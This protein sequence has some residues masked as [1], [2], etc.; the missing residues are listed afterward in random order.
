MEQKKSL[1]A[2]IAASKT[3]FDVAEK[4]VFV[5]K[6]I[7]NLSLN[8]TLLLMQNAKQKYTEM[9]SCQ[10]CSRYRRNF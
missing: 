4:K 9:K 3:E 5:K 2:K 8:K 10:N 1:K 7:T 6:L